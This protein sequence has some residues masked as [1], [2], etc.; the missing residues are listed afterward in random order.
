MMY[1]GP[2]FAMYA[3]NATYFGMRALQAGLREDFSLDVDAF[4]KALRTEKPALIYIAYPNNPTGAV[5]PDEET[6]GEVLHLA[7]AP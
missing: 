4:L 6:V 3:M 5:V 1:P 2:T 7:P